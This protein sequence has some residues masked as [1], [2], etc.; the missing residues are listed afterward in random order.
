MDNR[1]YVVS[2]KNTLISLERLDVTC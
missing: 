2:G 1:K